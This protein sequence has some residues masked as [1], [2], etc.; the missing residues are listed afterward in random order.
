M[1]VFFFS[2]LVLVIAIATVA[3][4]PTPTKKIFSWLLAYRLWGGV[5]MRIKREF[6]DKALGG[7]GGGGMTTRTTRR[8]RGTMGMGQT[9]PPGCVTP[10]ERRRTLHRPLGL[11]LRRHLQLIFPIFSSSKLPFPSNVFAPSLLLSTRYATS[12][13]LTQSETRSRRHAADAMKRLKF[14]VRGG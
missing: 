9:P 11:G 10:F 3:I 5:S 2:S 12:S 13:S 8:R 1:K 14:C 7:G 6:W 4:V